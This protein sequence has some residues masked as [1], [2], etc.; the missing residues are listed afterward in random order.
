MK[1]TGFD[2]TIAWYDKNSGGAIHPVRTKDPNRYGLYDMLG[3]V[4]EWTAVDWGA[5][6]KV[7]RG[8]SLDDYTRGVRA[9]FS[10][11]GHDLGDEEALGGGGRG[12]RSGRML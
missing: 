4:W 7:V 10:A 5:G 9:S 2:D 12:D 8:G 3:N 6:G 1:V 11:P